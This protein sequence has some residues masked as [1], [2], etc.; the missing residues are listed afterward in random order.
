[1]HRLL[2]YQTKHSS[3][4]EKNREHM[5]DKAGQNKHKNPKTAFDE[6]L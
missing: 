2:A 4:Q 5:T 1:M 6:L 3:A